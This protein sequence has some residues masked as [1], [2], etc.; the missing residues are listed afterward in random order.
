MEHNRY[1]YCTGDP[2]VDIFY[3]GYVEA[4]DPF[5][6]KVESEKRCHGGALN[7]WKNAEALLGEEVVQFFSPT[8][9]LAQN[10][11]LQT[12]DI[13]TIR[14][15]LLGLKSRAKGQLILESSATPIPDKSHF[16]ANATHIDIL[17]AMQN[18]YEN[19]VLSMDQPDLDRIG[20]LIA[21]YNKGSVSKNRLIKKE[22]LPVLKNAFDFCIVDSR[23]RSLD[24][25]ILSA[26]RYNIWHATGNE[27]KRDFSS[28]F[29]LILWTNGPHDIKILRQSR[30]NYYDLSIP[31]K[32]A[33][34][35]DECGAGDTFTAAIAAYLLSH[36]DD[37]SEL[38][39][40]DSLELSKDACEFAIKC[41]R[42]VISRPFT[43]ITKIKMRDTCTLQTS[44]KSSRS[45]E[46]NLETT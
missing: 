24:P 38:S 44:K 19:R 1:L 20:L 11:L 15:Y 30:G 9:P 25:A 12:E 39:V 45:L 2:I 13:Y 40:L 36:P 16:Y 37:I 32:K 26:S 17:S 5:V 41:C 29:D 27:Y 43:S 42:D 3:T 18:A 33:K 8:G 22:V 34:I 23:Y 31:V 21:D 28:H 35:I 7:T 14:R 4:N 10:P 6:F 46:E